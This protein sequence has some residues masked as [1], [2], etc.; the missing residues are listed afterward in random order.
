M[1]KII[2]ANPDKEFSIDPIVVVID[3]AEQFTDKD[4]RVL[5]SFGATLVLHRKLDLSKKSDMKNLIQTTEK[6][7]L[8][9]KK[10]FDTVG[11][12]EVVNLQSTKDLHEKYQLFAGSVKMNNRKSREMLKRMYSQQSES[13]G[14]ILKARQLKKD[15]LI[16]QFA[17]PQKGICGIQFGVGRLERA[18]VDKFLRNLSELT[19]LYNGFLADE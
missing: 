10:K 8:R 5:S 1:I 17:A 2:Q 19:S 6:A 13:S 15:S 18:E 9:L 3:L 11:L 12:V 7:V 14:I 16:S 4:V